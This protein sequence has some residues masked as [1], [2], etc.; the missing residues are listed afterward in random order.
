MFLLSG[1]LF[2]PARLVQRLPG[3]QAN[4]PG[5]HPRVHTAA[6]P[7]EFHTRVRETT[8]YAFVTHYAL[9]RYLVTPDETFS[10]E[11]ALAELRAKK[12]PYLPL[13]SL[14][15]PQTRFARKPRRWA[16]QLQPRLVKSLSSMKY[17]AFSMSTL[18]L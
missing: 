15:L 3:R 9:R 12:V 1:V 14:T 7:C 4:D 10:K 2:A 17:F 13:Q 8:T 5:A 6:S 11:K 18:L 16:A